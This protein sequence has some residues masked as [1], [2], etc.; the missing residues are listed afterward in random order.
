MK[1]CQDIENLLPLYGEG[2]LADAEKKAVDEHLAGCVACQKELARLQK[3]GQL[4][5]DVPQ[6]EEPPWFQQKIMARVREEADKKS[7][8]QKGFYSLRM[9]IPVQIAATLVIAVLAVY[10]Y[11]SGDEQVKEILP[12]IP[13][14]AVEM[15]TLPAPAPMPQAGD[16]AAPVVPREKAAARKNVKQDKPVTGSIA[17]GGS[18]QQSEKP[19][20]RSGTDETDAYRVKGLAESKEDAHR[21]LQA[22][23]NKFESAGA[24]L[25]DQ[26]KKATASAAAEKRDSY[27]M[28]APAAPQSMAA[29]APPLPEASVFMRVSDLNAA[30]A[31]VEKTLIKYSAKKVTKQSVDD[32]VLV[33]A[34]IAGRDWQEVL[35]KLKEIG[36]VKEKVMI[37]DRSE[38]G[39]I[40]LIE[41]A[42]Q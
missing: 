40:V 39:I 22:K 10:I 21:T 29:S 12:G 6:V 28:A 14:P 11:R 36:L 2:V 23:Q 31:E 3:A 15:Q 13:K 19:E 5:A 25:T 37:S 16:T 24:R 1:K 34:E 20:G 9:K 8:A 26:E 4:V 42:L 7:I 41:I 32:R 35:T 27:Q 33:Q 30:A 17:A 18:V 38:R